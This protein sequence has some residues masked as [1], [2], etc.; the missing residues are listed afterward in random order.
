MERENFFTFVARELNVK[1]CFV[2][3][4]TLDKKGDHERIFTCF[5]QRKKIRSCG[6]WAGNE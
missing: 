3:C 1:L 4:Q 6:V 5:H 2:C